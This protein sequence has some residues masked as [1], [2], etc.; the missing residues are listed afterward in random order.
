VLAFG[1]SNTNDEFFDSGLAFAGVEVGGAPL[2]TP[3]PSSFVLIGI[4]MGALAVAVRSRRRK[5]A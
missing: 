1:V 4:A 3:E 5:T 2:P